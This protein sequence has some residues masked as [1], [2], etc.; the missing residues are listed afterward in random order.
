MIIHAEDLDRARGGLDE[1]RIVDEQARAG[2][3][4]RG[5]D[6]GRRLVIMVARTGEHPALQGAERGQ[7]LGQVLG[8]VLRLHGEEV[9]GEHDEIGITLDRARADAAQPRDG[10]ER[11]DVRI[12]DLDDAERTSAR[13]LPRVAPARAVADEPLH[14]GAVD[15]D[16]DLLAAQGQRL[17]DPDTRQREGNP[18]AV[19]RRA[20]PG[21]DGPGQREERRRHEVGRREAHQRP[22]G[23]GA[24]ARPRQHEEVQGRR[25]LEGHEGGRERPDVTDER[26]RDQR[27]QAEEHAD[28]L[29]VQRA[30]TGPR[31]DDDGDPAEGGGRPE[32]E[33]ERKR[34]QGA[35]GTSSPSGVLRPG[36]RDALCFL[37]R[38]TQA[39]QPVC[40]RRPSPPH[41]PEQLGQG[42][43]EVIPEN[44]GRERSATPR[45]S[46]AHGAL[47]EGLAEGAGAFASVER[48]VAWTTMRHRGGRCR[49]SSRS[50]AS[51]RP[52][53]PCR[54]IATRPTSSPSSAPSPPPSTAFAGRSSAASGTRSTIACSSSTARGATGSASIPTRRSIDPAFDAAAYRPG[55]EALN[56][57]TLQEPGG[58]G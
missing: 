29:R 4:E 19:R 37:P 39:C 8:R 52:T 30:A 44:E 10:H 20:E 26:A 31:R 48:E 22:V 16:I 35:P 43:D 45:R 51:V 13:P 18:E 47:D 33:G 23:Q 54:S 11:A 57:R 2:P 49:A 55:F 14:R 53:A 46:G 50:R 58:D 21:R 1:R 7:R 56:F 41:D 38:A 40:S 15:E 9:A 36:G 28:E 27:V 24:H 17:E 6:V 3:G 34:F 25:A 12:G 5:R 42:A 32:H